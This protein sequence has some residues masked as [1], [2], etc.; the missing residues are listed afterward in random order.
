M[1]MLY[2]NVLCDKKHNN[3][4][5]VTCADHQLP[6]NFHFQKNQ[7]CHPTSWGIEHYSHSTQN[8]TKSMIWTFLQRPVGNLYKPQLSQ[9]FK[10]ICLNL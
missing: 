5:D 2:K 4:F 7:S 6:V 9:H 10:R 1:S 8:G 3:K